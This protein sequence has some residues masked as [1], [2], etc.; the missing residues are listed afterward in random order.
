MIKIIIGVIILA[1]GFITTL[2]IIDP[3]TAIQSTGNV[4]EVAN[5]FTV[6]VEGEVYNTGSYTMNDGA[7]MSDLIKAAGGLKNSADVRA[8]YDEAILTKGTTYYIASLFD[9][10]DLCNVSEVDKV[11]INEDNAATLSTVN[12]ITSSIA[13]SIVTYRN[14]NGEFSTLEDLQLVY[15]IGPSTYRK[16]RNYVILHL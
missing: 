14:E 9:A 13:N 8:F 15:G 2:L 4:T 11:N 3:N 12:G 16:I 7:T 5:A 6:A 10:N 1:V